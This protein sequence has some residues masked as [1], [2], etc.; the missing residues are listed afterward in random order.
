MSGRPDRQP[1]EEQPFDP[2]LET[3]ENANTYTPLGPGDER[4][5]AGR[6]VLWMGR[7]D[8]PAWNVAQRFRLQAGEVGEVIEEV[9]AHLRARGRTACTW[10][11]GSS[12]TP[13]DLADRLIALGL[14]ELE[15]QFSVGMVLR[16]DPAG[17]MPDG[18]SVRRSASQ[19][20][21]QVA[22]EIA[23]EC[24]G[25][26]PVART[27]D[28]GSSVVTYLAFLDGEPVGRA[29][30]SFGEHSVSLFGGATLPAARGRGVY[31]AL[32]HARVRDAAA[33]G[34][35]VAITQGGPQSRPILVRLGFEELCTIRTLLDPFDRQT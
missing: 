16:G 3:A 25:G 11:V 29:T 15:D 14:V 33:R 6:Y 13:G 24:F 5:E 19:E 2:I 23:A 9:H 21:E 31:R 12:A 32:V 35:P 30:G 22:A 7:A 26:T 20:E 1:G 8:E 17:A 18:V 28:P 10:E 34:T 27:F 4:I